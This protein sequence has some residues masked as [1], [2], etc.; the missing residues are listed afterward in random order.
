MADE[1][2]R[3]LGNLQGEFKSLDMDIRDRTAKRMVAAAGGVLKKEARAIAL[4]KKLFKSGALINNIVIKREPKAGHGVEQY[5]LGVRHGR[6]LGNGKKVI[7]FLAVNSKG[8]VVTRRKND[9]FYWRFLEFGHKIVPRASGKQGIIESLYTRRT[10]KGKVRDVVRKVQ[11]D[12][13]SIRRRNPTGFVEATPF[14]APALESKRQD[15]ID[16]MEKQARKMVEAAN[17]R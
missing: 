8:R 16:A 13:I 15:A 14:L 7:K 3:G 9:P 11:A 12:A 5:N 10:K 6:G 2:I 4:R 1:I 17:K